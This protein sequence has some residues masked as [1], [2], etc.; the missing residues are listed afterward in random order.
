MSCP[1]T[2]SKWL[3]GGLSGWYLPSP[4]VKLPETT[5]FRASEDDGDFFDARSIAG[6]DA[7]SFFSARAAGSSMGD[8]SEVPWSPCASD[9]HAGRMSMQGGSAKKPR[10]LRWG[11]ELGG[12][13]PSPATVYGSPRGGGAH[14]ESSPAV[15]SFCMPPL[16]YSLVGAVQ[17]PSESGMRGWLGEAH[18]CA[19]E[20]PPVNLFWMPLGCS[21]AGPARE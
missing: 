18:S 13:P 21:L 19:H 12:V 8:P 10:S 4:A 20:S 9:R 2:P 1:S 15:N 3:Q 6:S 7:T 16:G 14:A 11:D 17:A 5:P